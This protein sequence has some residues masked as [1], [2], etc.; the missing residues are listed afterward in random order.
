M[1]ALFLQCCMDF[2]IP[3]ALGIIVQHLHPSTDLELN[4]NITDFWK[5]L[6]KLMKKICFEVQD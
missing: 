3:V 5:I 6:F 1:A 2:W 4:Y